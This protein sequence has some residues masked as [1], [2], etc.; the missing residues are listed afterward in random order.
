[1][2]LVSNEGSFPAY[3]SRTRTIRN[4]C[5]R[6]SFETSHDRRNSLKIRYDARHMYLIRAK[7]D[8]CLL[9]KGHICLRMEGLFPHIYTYGV[10]TISR[11]LN[12]IGLFCRNSSLL[13]GSFA[14]ET[15]KLIDPT[16]RSHPISHTTCGRTAVYGCLFQSIWVIFPT[17]YGSLFQN[18]WVFFPYLSLLSHISLF[19]S[20]YMHFVFHL[21][22]SLFP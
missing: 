18:I 3:I 8:I 15:Y 12:I 19:L 17:K 10:A 13:Q 22:G 11:L 21:Y 20:T 9:M 2:P 1:M 5:L 14:K 16:N 4:V 6:V 7:R